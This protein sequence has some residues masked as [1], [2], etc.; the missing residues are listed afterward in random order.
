MLSFA[1]LCFTYY[2][3]NCVLLCVTLFKKKPTISHEY[4]Y[5][6]ISNL[7]LFFN[8]FFRWCKTVCN[9]YWHWQNRSSKW[10]HEKCVQIWM[11][12]KALRKSI[13][14]FWCWSSACPSF[15]KLF[16]WRVFKRSQKCHVSPESLACLWL[17]KRFHWTTWASWW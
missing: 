12:P 13:R 2:K 16:F 14:S 6:R 5:W 8:F 3:V 1:V 10:W 15:V 4:I 11:C 17:C 9:S 7:M